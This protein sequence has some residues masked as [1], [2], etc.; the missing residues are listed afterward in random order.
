[1]TNHDPFSFPTYSYLQ[2]KCKH[3]T[4]LNDIYC[5]MSL[6]VKEY[7]M[8]PYNNKFHFV[9]FVMSQ[10]IVQCRF[11][12]L[13]VVLIIVEWRCQ[14]KYGRPQLTTKLIDI[15]TMWSKIASNKIRRT[16]MRSYKNIA[17]WKINQLF[18][19]TS[20]IIQ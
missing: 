18:V 1:M 7:R 19:F 6:S 16:T 14:Q 3:K 4:L 5:R 17:C 12:L 10:R 20:V 11:D 2:Y 8:K 13:S 9:F 15:A